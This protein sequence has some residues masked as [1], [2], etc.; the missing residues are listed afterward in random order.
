[1]SDTSLYTSAETGEQFRGLRYRPENTCYLRDVW[2]KDSFREMGWLSSRSRYVHLYLNG[3][4]W[5][6]YQPS[7]ALN[8]AYF[9][10]HLGGPEEAWDVLVGEDNNGP[11]EIVDGSGVGW[12]NVLNLVNAGITTEAAYAAVAD[13]VDLDNLI[14]YMILHI[15][16][17]AEDWPRHNWYVARRR[18]TN[19]LPATKFIC[20]VWDQE[21]SLDRLVRRN[22]IDVGNGS[23]PAGEAYSPGRVYSQLRAWPEFRLRFADRV[24]KHFFHGGAL[25]TERAV[26]RLLASAAII[27]D[28]VNAESARWGDARKTGVPAGQIGTG[29]TFT[30]D[31]WWQ[32]EIDKLATNFLP[33]LLA[34]NLAR[35]RAAN[36]YPPIGAPTLLPPGGEVTNGFSVSISHT[37]ASGTIYLTLD[38]S[39][40]REYGTGLVSSNALIYSGPVSL[41]ASTRI[42][43]RVR[44]GTTWSA[45]S[46][47]DF[48]LAGALP[49]RITEIMYHPAPPS[50]E[51]VA[52]GFTDADQFEYIELCNI[53]SNA[54]ALADVRFA[55]GIGFAFAAGALPPGARVVL[56]KDPAAFAF[57]HGSNRPVAGTFVGN[58]ANG[59]ERLRLLDALGG[60][61]HDFSYDD[62]WYPM[63]DGLGFSLTIRDET[64]PL[65]TWGNRASWRASGSAR[66]TPGTADPGAPAFPPVVIN[67]VLSRPAG[68]ES[69]AIEVLN[70]GLADADLSHWWLS[71]DFRAPRKYRLAPGTVCPALG[72][73]VFRESEF[74]AEPGVPPAFALGST[75]GGVWLFSG[76]AAGELTGYAHGFEFGPAE[77]GRSFGRLELSTAAE[78]F[79]AQQANT[80]GAPNAGPRVGPVIITE[81]H[82]RPPDLL[83][84]TNAVDNS[85]DEFIELR[86]VSAADVPLFDPAAPTNTWRLRAA[87]DF[88]FPTN[89]WLAPGQ[90]AVLVGFDPAADAAA[91][92]AFLDAHPTARNALLLG[93]W[94]G[95]LDNSGE[96]IELKRPELFGTNGTD[97]ILVERVRYR[98]A[99]PWPA[100]A[101]GTG[102]SLHRLG[103]AT[104]AG[105]PIHWRAAAPS[106]G[107][108]GLEAD[109]DTDGLPDWW[110][111]AFGTDPEHADA[112]A[113]PDADGQVNAEEYEA[114]TH[115]VDGA[116]RLAFER[117]SVDEDRL[118]L[119]F[120]AV[121]DRAYTI[122]ASDTVS[123]ADW[124]PLIRLEPGR[125]TRLETV[126][127]ARPATGVRFYRLTAASGDRKPG[128]RAPMLMPR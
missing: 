36:L 2:V 100:E 64:A 78:E 18:A 61:V 53:G 128:G 58:L 19:G 80:L 23:G 41:A 88:D 123:G 117:V 89:L 29:K 124:T 52:A 115:P 17:E 96:S 26:A 27:R 1:Y 105:D 127:V 92:T 60:V 77:L 93:P 101:D 91:R 82:Y 5:G 33:R 126:E 44:Q 106:A 54:L 87:V 66:G 112:G 46:E 24:Q 59:G 50:A 73:R 67:E 51:E 37:N 81:F 10:A 40:P 45:L 103:M 42:K 49:L 16:A 39:D 43:A 48:T 56:V 31:E 28:A 55:S 74:N 8:A 35:F 6:L 15:Y 90:V 11:P 83:T 86:N 118:L 13:L 122:L 14:D 34:D 107:A 113:D 99:A 125:Q 21:L 97:F 114:G 69:D 111:S 121:A 30:R 3:L 108:A 94:L 65:S 95:K 63:T 68:P 62:A 98:D 70:L 84:G 109:S 85:R 7:E 120:R 72:T 4:Y 25:S 71:D 76:N 12:T 22:R 110:E 20:A 116:S 104:F 79:V 47:A 57:R 102:A 38:G 75:G 32:P 9:A 119:A